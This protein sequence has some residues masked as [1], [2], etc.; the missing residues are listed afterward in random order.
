M[1][2]MPDILNDWQTTDIAN[3]DAT[4]YFVNPCR[5]V[6]Q[7]IWNTANSIVAIT[8]LSSVSN[9]SS[10]Y[11]TSQALQAAANNFM[12]HTDRISGMTRPNA[13]TATKPHYATAIG[14]GKVVMQI[15]FQT[16]GV[17]NNAPM[18]GNFTSLFAKSDLE[19]N[20]TTISGYPTLVSTNMHVT[21]DFGDPPELTYTTSL[22]PTQVTTITN[23]LQATV[24]LLN[25]R[26]TSDENFFANTANVINDYNTLK[27]FSNPGQTE[28]Y[29]L[30]NYIGS[31]KLLSR[32]NS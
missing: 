18:M 2:M 27:Q 1:S 31:T 28:S 19:A 21:S 3:S 30:N 12:L 13:D 9:A 6:T 32:L 16:D 11:T 10:I 8:G 15:T 22:T 29:L 14:L 26:R 4:G 5:V 23:G 25:S 7:S 24:D 17:Q 20:N